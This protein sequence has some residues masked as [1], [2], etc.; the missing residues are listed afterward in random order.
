MLR[1]TAER[2]HDLEEVHIPLRSDFRGRH[3][4]RPMPRKSKSDGRSKEAVCVIFGWVQA[5]VKMAVSGRNGVAIRNSEKVLPCDEVMVARIEQ[6]S[7][8]IRA[9][10]HTGIRNFLAIASPLVTSAASG[11]IGPSRFGVV[12]T[13]AIPARQHR[14]GS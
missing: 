7:E 5:N 11:W 9:G 3:R 12:G 10:A 2:L 1:W 13:S 6:H 4:M 14:Q 8:T